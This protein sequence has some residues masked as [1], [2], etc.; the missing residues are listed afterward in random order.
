MS[1]AGNVSYTTPP[2]KRN[3]PVAYYTDL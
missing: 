2:L 3:R 1:K